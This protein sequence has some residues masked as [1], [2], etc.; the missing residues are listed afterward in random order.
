MGHIEQHATDKQ[1][2]VEDAAA[3][4]RRKA[5]ADGER[6]PVS[7]T[8]RLYQRARRLIEAGEYEKALGMLNTHASSDR[9]KNAMGVCLMRMRRVSAAIRV[10]RDLV[11][12]AGCTWM[13]PDLP[14]VYRTNF[15]T[16]LL[17]GGHRC[18]CVDILADIQEQQHPSVIRLR[19]AIAKWKSELSFRQRVQWSCGLEPEHALELDFLPGEFPEETAQPAAP[20]QPAA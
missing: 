4:Y 17:L 6:P 15:C 7:E 14:V 2:L 3:S 5:Q 11:L 13:R 1:K 18:G 16:A 10:Y 20:H 9:L 8:E 19:G 12:S